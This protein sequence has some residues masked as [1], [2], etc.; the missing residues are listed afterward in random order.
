MSSYYFWHK[1]ESLTSPYSI[2][3]PYRGPKPFAPFDSQAKSWGREFCPMG[4]VSFAPKPSIE[5]KFLNSFYHERLVNA[6]TEEESVRMKNGW[7]C[8]CPV[9]R[10]RGCNGYKPCPSWIDQCFYCRR[11][12]RSHE[13]RLDD[14]ASANMQYGFTC[15]FMPDA[16]EHGEY[17]KSVG[18]W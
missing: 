10:H 4:R 6:A 17:T 18:K 12:L 15:V 9:P 11:A 7:G 5:E 8:N 3:L 14:D 1:W 16:G 13:A 2:P